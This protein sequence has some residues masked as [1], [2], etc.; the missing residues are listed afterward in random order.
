MKENFNCE[1]S[2]ELLNKCLTD[3]NSKKFIYDQIYDYCILGESDARKNYKNNKH[4]SNQ[5][6]KTN[7]IKKFIKEEVSYLLSNRPTYIS[8][9]DNKEA[10]DFIGKK[11]GHW[12]KNHNKEVLRDL[13]SYGSVFELYYVSKKEIAGKKEYLFN[14]EIISPR[15]GYALYNDNKE[16]ILFMRF[17]K[18]KFDETQYVDVYSKNKI[19]HFK[20]G[21]VEDKPPTVNIFKEVP[22][23]EGKVSKYKDAD[24]LFNDIRDL[25]DAYETNLSDIVNE[26]SDYR[27]AYLLALGCSLKPEDI[28]ELK[29]KGIINTESKDVTFKFLTKDINDTFVQ[30]TLSTLKKNIYEIS[31]HLDTNEKLQSNTSGSALRNRLIGLEQRVRDSEGCMQ[32]IIIHRI[33]FMFKLF[34]KTE[35]TKFDFRDIQAKFTLNIPQDDV[36]TAQV[37]SQMGIGEN[38]SL[39]TALAQLSFV[40]NV[41]REKNLI[42][43]NKEEIA[44][45]IDLDK[46]NTHTETVIEEGAEDES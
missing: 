6:V 13:L 8:K 16:I 32:D 22:V 4:R 29:A 37:L 34:N 21:W 25:Q 1:F 15:E 40:N 12:S 39:D 45:E 2:I 18:K 5:K 20:D 38:I 9:S 3:F 28:E 11:I 23:V 7:F 27:L 30:N 17:F 31:N 10:I 36:L 43:K 19:Y 44:D 33:Y 41:E 42:K 46:V 26:I 35:K 24:T 14:L